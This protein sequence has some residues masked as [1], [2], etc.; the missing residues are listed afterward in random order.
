MTEEQRKEMNR[1][2]GVATVG[3]IVKAFKTATE[4]LAD[5]LRNGRCELDATALENLAARFE[6]E[7]TRG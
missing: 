6:Y 1:R 3:E 5:D 4:E 2:R 7:L